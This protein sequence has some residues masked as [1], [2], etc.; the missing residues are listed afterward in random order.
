MKLCGGPS[1]F[2]LDPLIDCLTNMIPRNEN[3]LIQF[4]KSIEKPCKEFELKLA[5]LG[6]QNFSSSSSSSDSQSKGE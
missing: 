6:L 1:N 2:L 5:T 4:Q 3:E